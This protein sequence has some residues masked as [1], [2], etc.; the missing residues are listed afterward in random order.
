MGSIISRKVVAYTFGKRG[1][2][3]ILLDKLKDYK[4]DF[5]FTDGWGSCCRILDSTKH[6]VSK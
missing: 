3:K 6:I 1:G 4:I 5:Y 2:N